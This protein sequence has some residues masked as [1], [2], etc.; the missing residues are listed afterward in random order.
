MLCTDGSGDHGGDRPDTA[1]LEVQQIQK[2]AGGG[3]QKGPDTSRSRLEE[4][5]LDI[6]VVVVVVVGGGGGGGGDL[7]PVGGGG[8]K[9]PDT[10]R[11]RLE[12]WVMDVV[13][14]LLFVVVFV[15]L[16][17]CWCGGGGGGNVEQDKGRG[18]QRHWQPPLQAGWVN[19][20]WQ[21]WWWWWWWQ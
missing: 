20:G 14:V 4:W 3:E 13:I 15:I 16:C 6:L 7:E 18:T 17:C 8:Q 12:Q 1:D 10:S 5:V 9:G 21:R 2:Q 11:Y 19:N